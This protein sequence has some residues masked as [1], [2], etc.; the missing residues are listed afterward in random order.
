MQFRFP[1][2]LS[3]KR[4]IAA[5][6]ADA[7]LFTI[8]YYGLYECRFGVWPPVSPRLA[9]LLSVWSLSSYVVGRYASGAR[10]NHARDT[11]GFLV[12]N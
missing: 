7:T 12:G 8:F 9:V 11:W 10:N 5:V 6:L 1:W 4:L 2:V 3:R